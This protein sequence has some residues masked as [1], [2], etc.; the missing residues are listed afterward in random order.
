VELSA[1]WHYVA[2]DLLL[3]AIAAHDWRVFKRVYPAT[4]VG[5]AVLILSQVGREWLSRSD[6]W[7]AFAEWLTG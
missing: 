6:S 1:V 5:G 3:V 2:I 4:L 7:L